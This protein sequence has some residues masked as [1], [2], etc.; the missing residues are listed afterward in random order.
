MTRLHPRRTKYP[1]RAQEW[2]V[3]I[4]L[5]LIFAALHNCVRFQ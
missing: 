3:I 1:T 5:C 4:V 2:L